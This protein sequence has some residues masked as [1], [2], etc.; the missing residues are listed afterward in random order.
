[1]ID[2]EDIKPAKLTGLNIFNRSLLT[3]IIYGLLIY[4]STI[5]IFPPAA[6]PV[7][8]SANA[9]PVAVLL[10]NRSKYWPVIL[11][12]TALGHLAGQLPTTPFEIKLYLILCITNLLEIFLLAVFLRKIAGECPT[13]YR[14]KPFIVSSIWITALA[15]FSA[16]LLS[17]ILFSSFIAD[18]DFIQ[19]AIKTFTSTYLGQLLLLPAIIYYIVLDRASFRKISRNTAI[20]FCIIWTIFLFMIVATLASLNSRMPLYTIFPYITFPVIIWTVFRFGIRLTLT[21][22]II[23]SLLI[24]YLASLGYIPFGHSD[25]NDPYQI[26]QMNLALISLYGTILILAIIVYDQSQTKLD[27]AK[28]DEWFEIAINHMSGGLYLLDQ[29][30]RF[31][32]LSTN[33][34]D[35]FALPSDI[36]HLGAHIEPVFEFR[37]K[38]GDYG[39]G[40]PDEMVKQR[41]IELEGRKT[42]HGQN[43]SADGRTYEYYQNHTQDDEI[44]IIYYEVTERIKAEQDSKQ[45]LIEAQQANKA[46]TDFLANMSHELR[47]PLN[48]IIGFSEMMSKDDFGALSM[49]KVREYSTDIHMSGRHLLQI[50]NDILD[51]SKIEA[52]MADINPEDIHL[53]DEIRESVTFI[54]LRASDAD[55]SI[56]NDIV[57]TDTIIL[58]DKRMF[59]QIMVNLLSNSVKF[60][61]P[62]GDIHISHEINAAGDVTIRVADTGIGIDENNIEAMME[63]FRQADSS[64][65]R[66]F[67]GTGLGLPL[68]KSLME[69]HDGTIKIKSRIGEGTSVF[70]TFPYQK[71]TD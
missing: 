70:I 67:E 53:D 43:T 64:L 19:T 17:V 10:F 63:P 66:E 15:L 59:K 33:L 69:L 11:F 9:F 26:I 55:I 12:F 24:K 23:T 6:T 61:P 42:T 60:T 5:F 62:G 52:G 45:A 34:R 25:F 40:D 31:K 48:A 37:A 1:M 49:D 4:L 28:R 3:G 41:M 38:R 44:I 22:S 39:P 20:E 57:N 71:T 14:L 47:T 50:I 36:C 16:V 65:S 46:K 2:S 7:I 56:V 54:A 32:V 21:F 8:W 30:R 35:K 13:K 18:M 51:L 58:A 68:V 27:L 29:K